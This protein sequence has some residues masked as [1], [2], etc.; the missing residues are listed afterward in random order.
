MQS[1]PEGVLGFSAVPTMGPVLDFMRVVWA[2]DHAL[3]KTSKRME[4]VLGITAPQRLVIRILGRFPG[5]SAGLLAVV[6]HLHPST[7]TGIL[8]RLQR[9]GLITRRA[10]PRDHRRAVF[11]LTAKGRS[12]DVEAEG[13]VEAA[14]RIA[15]E[16][17]PKS[18]I[19]N[20]AEVFQKLTHL[21]ESRNGRTS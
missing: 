5:M 12:L 13:T 19:N 2:L 10:D 3:Q 6:L 11:G 8:K 14:V 21:L 9:R 17:I 16:Q 15:F 1:N 18:K 4:T 7:L 20:A